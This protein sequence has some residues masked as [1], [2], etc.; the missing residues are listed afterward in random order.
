M[1]DDPGADENFD[2]ELSREEIESKIDRGLAQLDAG[3]GVDGK[4]FVEELL[5]RGNA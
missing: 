3:E 4:T 5:R 2:E 1:K